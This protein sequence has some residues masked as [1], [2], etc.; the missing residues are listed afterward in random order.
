MDMAGNNG[1]LAIPQVGQGP[2][3]LVLHAWWGLNEF[4]KNLCERLA[5][6]GFVAY[7]PDLYGGK[8]AITSEDA[9]RLR[10]RLSRK[11]VNQSLTAAAQLLGAHR[12][13]AGDGLGVI[14]FS[15]GAYY[16]LGLSVEIPDVFRAVVIFYGTRGGEYTGSK[17]SY[18]CHFAEVDEWVST[19]GMKGL[20][21]SLRLANRPVTFHTYPDTGHWFFEAN[22]PSA[23]QPEAAELAWQRTLE[24]LR[25]ELAHPGS[26]PLR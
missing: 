14:G 15:M 13:V 18:L 9:E 21:K 12:A 16:A 26:Q 19:S 11:Q 2:G 6:Q 20:Q 22:R 23:Y 17:S 24:F 4:F 8:T 7:A 10:S 5:D 3:I 25:A 1:Y